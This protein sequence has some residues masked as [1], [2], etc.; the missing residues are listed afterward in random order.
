MPKAL[1]MT[2]MVIAILVLVL[3]LADLLLGLFGMTWLAPFK[4]ASMMMDILFIV[5][6]LI[7]GWLSWATLREQD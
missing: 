2:G 5:C 1:C 4:Y 6:A 3:F 7:L